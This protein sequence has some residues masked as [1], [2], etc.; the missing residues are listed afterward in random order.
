M[1]KFILT[2][3]LIMTTSLSY[4]DN[5]G[6]IGTVFPITETDFLQYIQQKLQSMKDSGQITELQNDFSKQVQSST[7]RPH[8]VAG[9]S[10][11]TTKRLF[12]FDP[13]IV[14]L[15]DIVTPTG[16]VIA[17]AGKRFNPL[18]MM[19]FNET[20]VFIN[21]DSQD[22]MNWLTQNLKYFNHPKIVLVQGNIKDTGKIFNQPIYFDQLGTLTKK[23]NITHVPA[24]VMQSGLK[25]AIMEFPVKSTLN[26]PLSVEAFNHA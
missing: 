15:K 14:V 19:T 8:P 20:L 18:T 16:I 1:R 12:Y 6:V 11:T 25:L 10:E 13:T 22:E 17:K 9:L 2:V 21:A 5:L 26:A 23:F 24:V 4:A 3:V 7:I